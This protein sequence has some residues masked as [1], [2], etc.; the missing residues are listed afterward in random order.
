MIELLID[1]IAARLSYRPVPVKLLETLAMLFDCDSVFQREHKNKPYNYSLDKTL[2]T[3]VLSTPP[4]ASSMFSFYKRNNSYGW[5]CQII[6]RFVLKDGINN[7]RKQF[8]DRK[9]FTALEY[10]ALLLPFANCMNCLIKTRYLQLFGKEIIQALDY[11]ENLSAEDHPITRRDLNSLIDVR[12]GDLTVEQTDVIV[13]CSSSKTLCENVFKSGGN[14]IKVSYEAELKKNPTA[15]IITVTANGHVAAKTIYFL[16]WQP[17]ADLIK[18]CDSV[19]T[20]VSNAMEKA[21]SESYQSIA[22]PAIGCGLH[23]CSISLVARTFVKE[24]HRQLFKY[25]MSVSFVDVIIGSSSSQILKR[26]I[27]NAAGDDVQM[28]YAKEHENNPNSLILSVPS[29]QLPCKRIFFVKWEPNTDEEA[30]QQS[31]VDLIWN[32]IQNAISHK[33][34]SIAF[35]SIGCGQ[36]SC[37]K[38]VIVKTMVREIKNQ[39]KMRNLPLTVKL[40]IAP[41]QL[42]IYDEFCKQVLSIEAD[43]STSISHELPSTW[44]QST[45]NK[46]RVIVSINTNEYKSIVTNFDQAMKGKYTQVIQ[47]ERIQN[48]R[49]YM[50]YLAHCRDFRKR[51]KIDTEK[52]LYHGCPEKA[53]DLII[54]D[55]FNR[56]F[57]GVNGKLLTCVCSRGIIRFIIL[58]GTVYGFGVYFSSNATYSH[59]YAIPNTKGERFMF[60]SRVLVGHTVLGNSS[61]KTRP[62]GYDS[63]TD[64]NH[65]FVTYH[66]AQ[67]FAEYLITYK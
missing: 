26:A 54:G 28:A 64:G 65:I 6:N 21:A 62:I 43:L 36:S 44:I 31:I 61:M 49:W 48:E 59:T 42:E 27:I 13:V 53:A 17:D 47:I 33:F 2:G 41:D 12:Q 35:P 14:S 55:C 5:L 4:A 32:V 67:A 15:P 30:L 19:K 22:I 56:S 29:G 45:E 9:R 39:L 46:V 37:S 40:S 58:L 24:V 23:G 11:I 52:R 63:T 1:L 18:F 66:D 7:L 20:F 3:R 34:T 50:Q 10:H 38:Q 16:P 25:P 8:E 51:L 60:V 57:A